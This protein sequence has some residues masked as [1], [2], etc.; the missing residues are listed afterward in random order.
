MSTVVF[1]AK[2]GAKLAELAPQSRESI[3]GEKW[4]TWLRKLKCEPR[5]CEQSKHPQEIERYAELY[6]RSSNY[7]GISN[8]LSNACIA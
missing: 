3:S 8:V 4:R 1:E 5:R 7:T 6:I 2:S